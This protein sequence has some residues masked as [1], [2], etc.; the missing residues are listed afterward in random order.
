MARERPR[1][2]PVRIPGSAEGS[3]WS[4]T[5]CQRVAPRAS[6]AWR[7]EMGTVR[8][9]SWVAITMIGRISRLSVSAPASRQVAQGQT[10]EAK[11][12]TKSARPRMP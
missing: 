11:R 9:A 3:T 6:A 8:S 7:S 4:L 1:I 2:V 12:P 10:L 5:I